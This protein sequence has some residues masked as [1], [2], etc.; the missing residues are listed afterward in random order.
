MCIPA[1]S[2]PRSALWLAASTGMLDQG[3]VQAMKSQFQNSHGGMT[4]AQMMATRRP[5]TAVNQ[6]QQGGG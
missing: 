3:R 1:N 5:P 4:A 6:L 2:T